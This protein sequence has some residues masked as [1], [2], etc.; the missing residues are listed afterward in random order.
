M[1]LFQLLQLV[2]GCIS[3]YT[4]A[5]FLGIS[6]ESTSSGI[7]LKRI[8]PIAGEIKKYKSV[9]KNNKKIHDKTLMLAK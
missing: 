2:A 8:C 4:S 6:L 5:S 3:I 7:G 9:I 1:F